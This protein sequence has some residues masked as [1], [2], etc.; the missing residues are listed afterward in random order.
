M[1]IPEANMYDKEEYIKKL[2]NIGFNNIEFSSIKN[3]V[4]PGMFKYTAQRSA[5]KKLEEA[6][7]ELSPKDINDCAGI[8]LWQNSGIGDYVVFVAQKT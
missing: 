1:Q 4:F 5:G 7:I 2:E 3:Y 8:E 6:T